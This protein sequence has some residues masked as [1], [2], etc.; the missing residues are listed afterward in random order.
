MTSQQSNVSLTALYYDLEKPTAF[1]S[2]KTLTDFLNQQKLTFKEKS[3]SEW[4][5]GQRA[6]ALHKPRRVRFQR[7]K[8]SATNIADMRICKV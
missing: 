6:Y 4:L 2:P 5:S 8:F 1:S 3:A 7:N